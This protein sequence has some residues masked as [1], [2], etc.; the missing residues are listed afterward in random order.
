MQIHFPVCEHIFS[1]LKQVYCYM[2][3]FLLILDV[4]NVI[5]I[6]ICQANLI[7]KDLRYVDGSRKDN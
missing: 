5:G 7:D 3:V 1:P 2:A 6:Y 4:Q